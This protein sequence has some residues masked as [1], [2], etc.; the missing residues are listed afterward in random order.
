MAIVVNLG[1]LR[2]PLLARVPD[3]VV[4][5]SLLLAWL[6][7]RRLDVRGLVPR[8]ARGA[9]AAA[10]CA[11]VLVWAGSM[12]DV[13]GELNRAGIAGRAGAFDKRMD[14]LRRRLARHAP[15]GN[16]TPSRNALA[17]QQFFPFVRRC[18]ARTDRIV[19]TGLSPDVFVLAERGF[20]GGQMAYR[21][22]FYAGPEDQRVALKRMAAE[23]VPY[24]VLAL[25]EERDFRSIELV[26]AYLDEHYVPM[27]TIPVPETRG[28][29]VFVSRAR[30]AVRTDAETGWPCFK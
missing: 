5:A 19:M 30:P 29:Q 3:A 2:S 15:D 11:A 17:L 10:A 12:A 1:F 26:A 14:E 18:T 25:E 21:P 22:N 27:A 9:T 23:S 20:A 7:G 13:T 24:F 16:W 6:L 28:L 4:P 8:L